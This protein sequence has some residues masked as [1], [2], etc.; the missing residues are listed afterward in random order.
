MNA[1][2]LIKKLPAYIIAWHFKSVDNK[3]NKKRM[4]IHEL[5]TK[6]GLLVAIVYARDFENS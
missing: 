1:A 5:Q 3:K 6:F 2:K 4:M